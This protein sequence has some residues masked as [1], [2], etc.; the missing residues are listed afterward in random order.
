MVKN[1]AVKQSPSTV[2]VIV[3]TALLTLMISGGGAYYFGYLGAGCA[4]YGGQS[5]GR[6]ARCYV[7]AGQARDWRSL[8]GRSMR[9]SRPALL[10]SSPNMCGRT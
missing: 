5:E 2:G 8:L 10:G 7:S 6:A 1:G 3:V 4:D 9:F